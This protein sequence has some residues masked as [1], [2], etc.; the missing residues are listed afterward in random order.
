[1]ADAGVEDV[2]AP[3]LGF[4]DTGVEPDAG[5]EADV[6]VDA[7]PPD[8]GVIDAGP[9]ICPDD[10]AAACRGA[11]DCQEDLTPPTNCD[12]C[13]PFNRALCVEGACLTPAVLD[14]SDLYNIAI[15]ISPSVIGVESFAT[16]AISTRT[17]G[18]RRLTCEDVYAGELDLDEDCVNIL[19]TRG[20][21]SLQSGDQFAL[22]FASFTSGE[23]TL[24]LA[25]GHDGAR[26][27]GAPLGVSCTEW[28]VPAPSGQ[29]PYFIEGGTMRPLP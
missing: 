13:R 11:Q 3:D 7:G 26:P 2:G 10:P 5:V 6:G 9:Q 15:T 14:T 19:D 18:D 12:P 16:F 4:P 20:Y 29:G 22:S 21:T 28:D 24:F 1:M 27:R 17:A 8:S 23:T 25:Y